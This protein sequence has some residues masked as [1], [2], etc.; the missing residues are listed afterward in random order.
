MAL[1]PATAVIVFTPARQAVSDGRW[2]WQR[3]Q[4]RLACACRC[5]PLSDLVCDHW[6]RAGGEGIRNVH[7]TGGGM[8]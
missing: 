1:R 8:R 5:N 4:H 2:W 3:R 6:G 7:Q